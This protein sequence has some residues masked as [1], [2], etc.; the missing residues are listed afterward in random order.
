MGSVDR[1]NFAEDI[2]NVIEPLCKIILTKDDTLSIE[3]ADGYIYKLQENQLNLLYDTN[4]VVGSFE[5]ETIDTII[6][7]EVMVY[8]QSYQQPTNTSNLCIGSPFEFDI[9]GNFLKFI[10]NIVQKLNEKKG[11]DFSPPLVNYIFSRIDLYSEQYRMFELFYD[12]R[13]KE[14]REKIISETRNK[15]KET[16]RNEIARTVNKVK[17]KL[18]REAE[19]ALDSAKKASLMAKSAKERAEEAANNEVEKKMVDVSRKVSEVSVTILG[20][21]SAIVLTVVAGLFYSS[22][23]IE[24]IS[25]ANFFTLLCI[26]SFV[27]FICFNLV[28]FLLDFILKINKRLKSEENKKSTN[29]KTDTENSFKKLL[30]RFIIRNYKTFVVNS[31]IIIVMILT[32]ILQFVFPNTNVDT[33]EDVK[34]TTSL[35]VSSQFVLPK[36]NYDTYNDIQETDSSTIS[37]TVSSQP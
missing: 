26:S 36:T 21:F 19:K 12:I 24:N 3:A 16:A 17:H 30:K 5:K 14:S 8:V 1:D 22:S 28:A 2:K 18:E 37:S 29:K 4:P 13:A 20:I 7:N 27:G 23:V 32:G 31:F 9:A 6:D 33:S 35:S 25:K 10:N 11:S 15:A 34:E